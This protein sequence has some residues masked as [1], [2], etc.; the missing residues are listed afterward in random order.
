MT[1]TVSPVGTSSLSFLKNIA[2]RAA[3]SF[4]VLATARAPSRRLTSARS[5]SSSSAFVTLAA[6][7]GGS[8]CYGAD[9]VAG[10]EGAGRLDP[11]EERLIEDDRAVEH[12]PRYDA[13]LVQRIA[14]VGAR[15]VV[16]LGVLQQHLSVGV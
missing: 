9:V 2:R 3:S 8:L 15:Q 7:I 13:R 4:A 11:K 6:G 1:L 5:L 14:L 16:K 12:F 10:R